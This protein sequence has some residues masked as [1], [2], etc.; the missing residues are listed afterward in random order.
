MLRGWWLMVLFA[1]GCSA[2]TVRV[3]DPAHDDEAAVEVWQEGSPKWWPLNAHFNA[4]SG[5]VP[6]SRRRVF[7]VP[8]DAGVVTLRC[9]LRTGL[10]RTT[11]CEVDGLTVIGQGSPPPSAPLEAANVTREGRVLRLRGA[12]ELLRP[13]S[14]DALQGIDTIEVDVDGRDLERTE[15]N[16]SLQQHGWTWTGNHW[17]SPEGA[18]FGVGL[19][20]AAGQVVELPLFVRAR[21]T[22]W[23]RA[24][25][26]SPASGVIRREVF[27][28]WI[29]GATRISEG[30]GNRLRVTCPETTRTLVLESAGTHP[31]LQYVQWLEVGPHRSP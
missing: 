19:Q 18:L 9:P 24:P 26:A 17:R 20:C 27:S 15:L 30:E 28:A 14:P 13:V 3:F 16:L 8:R 7:T 5:S 1:S 6:D 11:H 21:W 2:V 23:L 25:V 31:A 12:R 10:F 29:A 22:A 4:L